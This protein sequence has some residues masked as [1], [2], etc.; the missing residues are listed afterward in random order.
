MAFSWVS[1]SL[2]R[3]HCAKVGVTDSDKDASLPFL[4]NKYGEKVLELRRFY[5]DRKMFLNIHS[6]YETK[7]DND[8]EWLVR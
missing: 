8:K 6:E 5:D 4:G 1:F 7:N 2:S 3:E